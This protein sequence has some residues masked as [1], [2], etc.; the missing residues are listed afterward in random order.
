MELALANRSTKCVA[1]PPAGSK[2]AAGGFRTLLGEQARLGRPGTFLQERPEVR[3]PAE[4]APIRDLT[5]D[6]PVLW[7]PEIDSV[8][9]SNQS[10]IMTQLPMQH[11]G[12]IGIGIRSST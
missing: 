8:R 9:A 2:S 6:P 11:I 5:E 4:L 12:I 10:P 7:R 3:T 1:V